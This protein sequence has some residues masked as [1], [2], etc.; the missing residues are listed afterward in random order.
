MALTCVFVGGACVR[1]QDVVVM[2]TTTNTTAKKD[3]PAPHAA[4]SPAVDKKL[5]KVLEIA[6]KQKR[7][8]WDFQMKKRID[9]ITQATSLNDDG[10]KAL[11]TAEAQAVSASTDDWANKSLE[12]ARKQM[13]MFPQDQLLAMLDQALARG[14]ALPMDDSPIGG[15]FIAP[16]DQDVWTKALHQTLSPTQL[17]A[18]KQA[19]DKEKAAVEKE[20]STIL[21]NA[22]DRMRDQQNTEVMA[23]CKNL[24]DELKLPPD[25]A[26]QL[27]A[28]GKSA[29]DQSVEK[30]RKRV[31]QWLLSIDENQRRPMLNNGWYL[32]ANSDEL[33]MEQAL[34]KD[35][36]ARLLTDGER[37][38]LQSGKDARK[39]RREQV[40]GQVMVM[41]LDEKLALTSAQRQK[42]EP[43]ADRLVK[44][45]SAFYP[46]ASA[47]AYNMISPDCFYNVAGKA[48]DSELKPILDAV[49]LK[50]WHGLGKPE[51]PDDAPSATPAG[52]AHDDNEP[53]DVEKAISSFFY[54]KTESERK[55]E[56]EANTL[57]AEDAARVAGLNAESA[58][59]LEAAAAGATEQSLM[60]WKWFTEQQIRSQ[61]QGLTPQNVNERLAGLQDFFFQRRFGISNRPD[62]QN[63]WDET[64]QAEL[65]AQ[66]QDAWKK[67]TDARESY[68]GN[69]ISAVVLSEFDRQAHLT[70]DQL[71]KLHPLVTGVLNDY[72]QGIAQ[73]FSGVNGTPWYLGGPY[74]LIPL[75]GVEDQDLKS[76]LTKDQMDLWTGSQEFA[77]ANNLW[78]VV[79]QMHVQQGIQRVRRTA[80]AVIED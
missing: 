9:A 65:T 7:G 47:G 73:V 28:L 19:Q 63:I 76:I 59:R 42:L 32:G 79:K 8:Y 33:P 50:R 14:G 70:D 54:E 43:I 17:D 20:I 27:D 37:A 67:E 5:Q 15:Q 44:D 38:Q 75:A 4:L 29:I 57:K 80:R 45:V 16:E 36:L 21:K 77:N 58:E 52:P 46:D 31:E 53:E 2:E 30:Y 71:G 3:S 13:A 61:L 78:Q 10:V 49:Q 25:R 23:E 41:L 74:T 60:T 48:S 11:W 34:W 56:L 62:I 69:A 35:G 12:F 18:W 55:R 68:R 66:Q 22:A 1:A 26:A 72:S 40:M 51:T 64:V 6:K 24:E 39:A